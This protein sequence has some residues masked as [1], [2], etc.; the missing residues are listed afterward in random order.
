MSKILA[1]KYRPEKLSEIV[2]QKAI[3][4]LIHSAIEQNKLPHAMI[5]SG[6]RGIGKT[7]LARIVAK[8]LNCKDIQQFDACGVCSSCKAIQKGS[9][10][11]VCEMDAAS[12]TSVENV[13]EIIE[14]APYKAVLGGKRVY[15]IDEA[16]MLSKSAFNALLKNLEEPHDH[17]YYMLATTEVH[18]VPDTVM[19]RCMHLQLTPFSFDE[20]KNHLQLLL[21]KE[22]IIFDTHTLNNIVY[23]ADGSM[24]DALTLLN[25]AI[26]VPE[27]IRTCNRQDALDILELLLLGNVQ[28]ALS[29]VRT[30]EK[31]D[32]MQAMLD[33][34]YWCSCAKNNIAPEMHS[35]NTIQARNIVDSLTMTEL[36]HIW[37]ILH[38]GFQEY[39]QSPIKSHAI[40]MILLRVCYVQDNT[41]KKT[42][43]NTKNS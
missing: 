29:K 32:L 38:S 8:C 19:S 18:K 34:V 22:D 41:K 9:H 24:R 39:Q 26:L 4:K 23:L 6:I 36:L 3:V 35:I 25:Q 31:K 27:S 16:H 21:Q 20:I 37:K 1:L 2:G 42:L 15:I 13:R 5:L 43:I 11:D 12:H 28:D 17:V 30:T 33:I 14:S 40:E 7:S 10:I